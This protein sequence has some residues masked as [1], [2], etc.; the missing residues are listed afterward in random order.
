MTILALFQ[1]AKPGEN[2]WMK[3]AINV[4]IPYWSLGIANN[5]FMTLLIVFRMLMMR[6]MF[7][8]ALSSK[9]LK[10]YLSISAMLIESAALYSAFGI[11]YI[12]LF[13]RNSSIQFP[14]VGILDQVVVSRTSSP[15]NSTFSI[16]DFILYSVLHRS[17]SSCVSC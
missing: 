5:A 10:V 11:M 17:L 9:N 4:Y 6:R 15:I 8:G 12:I 1:T 13:T 14:I 2:L 16:P 7:S 3:N